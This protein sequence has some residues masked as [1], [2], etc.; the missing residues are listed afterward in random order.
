MFNFKNLR[1]WLIVVVVVAHVEYAECVSLEVEY[2]CKCSMDCFSPIRLKNPLFPESCIQ[3]YD[4]PCGKCLACRKNRIQDWS[5]RLMAHDKYS[6]G[7]GYFVTLTYSPE[8]LPFDIS[9]GLPM[10]SK[11]D[12][13]KFFKRLRKITSFKYFLVSEYGENYGRPHYH[14]IFLDVPLDERQFRKALQDTWKYGFSHC[15]SISYGACNYCV[16]Y[17]FKSDPNQSFGD[18][19]EN[20]R[21]IS[22]GLGSPYVDKMKSWHNHDV[23]RCFYPDKEYKKALPRYLKEKIYDTEFDKINLRV[24]MR[25]RKRGRIPSWSSVRIEPSDGNVADYAIVTDSRKTLDYAD[26][27][28]TKYKRSKSPF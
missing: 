1:L 13:Q 2:V 24:Y 20:F 19:V 11:D 10:V 7:N 12:V 5:C 17:I 18:A 23:Q 6:D 16:G 8:F 27:R 22:K 9:T 4:V 3:F 15:G 14:C 25:K 26:S 28:R 21:L